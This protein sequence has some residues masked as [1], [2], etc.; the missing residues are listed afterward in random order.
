MISRLLSLL[1]KHVSIRIFSFLD[2]VVLQWFLIDIFEFKACLKDCEF[3]TLSYH[4]WNILLLWRNQV[5]LWI[6]ESHET[7]GLSVWAHQS[8]KATVGFLSIER[9]A[10]QIE[11]GVQRGI[12]IRRLGCHI[13]V[14]FGR[15]EE[16]FR[17]CRACV[18][19]VYPHLRFVAFWLSRGKLGWDQW[20]CLYLLR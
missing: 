4:V 2:A 17:V 13:N 19:V 9:K 20:L 12:Q 15:N 11:R 18:Y 3:A 16:T 14:I 10:I 8:I 1:E 6:L 7:A 5:K